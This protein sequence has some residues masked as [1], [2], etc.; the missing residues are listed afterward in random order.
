MRCTIVERAVGAGES[1]NSSFGHEA[2]TRS[3]HRSHTRNTLYSWP[4]VARGARRLHLKFAL[5]KAPITSGAHF[6]ARERSA[7]RHAPSHC[8]ARRAPLPKLRSCWRRRCA[9]QCLCVARPPSAQ[10][11]VARRRP[12]A[13]AAASPL[14]R[15]LPLHLVLAH[16]L[17]RLC[18]CHCRRNRRRRCC[19]CSMRL[20]RRAV[21]AAASSAP[22]APFCD[23]CAKNLAPLS[24][25]ICCAHALCNNLA[26][27]VDCFSV[28]A[29]DRAPHRPNHPYRVI[30]NTLQP[31]FHPD[32][33]AS[34]EY[35][36]LTAMSQY[37]PNH[38]KPVSEYVGKGMIKCQNHYESVYLQPT[39][40]SI[41]FPVSLLHEPQSSNVAAATDNLAPQQLAPPPQST[42]TPSQNAPRTES[43][44]APKRDDFDVEWDDAAENLIADLN[45][46]SID[47][48]HAD[49]ATLNVLEHFNARLQR[50]YA[51]K[52]YLLEGGI[53][54]FSEDASHCLRNEQTLSNRLYALSWLMDHARFKAF[55]ESVMNEFRRAKSTYA[56]GC[57]QKEKRKARDLDANGKAARSKTNVQKRRRTGKAR[58]TPF[59]KRK[60]SSAKKHDECPPSP[61]ADATMPN[62]PASAPMSPNSPASPSLSAQLQVQPSPAFLRKAKKLRQMVSS[63]RTP[64]PPKPVDDMEDASQLSPAERNLCSTLHIPPTFLLEMKSVTLLTVTALQQRRRNEKQSSSEKIIVPP[65]NFAQKLDHMDEHSASTTKEDAN[66]VKEKEALI[67]PPLTLPQIVNSHVLLNSGEHA[68]E[69]HR[70]SQS[71]S[72]TSR[73]MDKELLDFLTHIPE[74]N[75]SPDIKQ[76]PDLIGK[77]QGRNGNGMRLAGG[78]SVKEEAKV[79]L[80]KEENV[81]LSE[82]CGEAMGKGQCS[83]SAKDERYSLFHST[84]KRLARGLGETQLKTSTLSVSLPKSKNTPSRTSEGGSNHFMPPSTA[85]AQT[86][87]VSHKEHSSAIAELSAPISEGS[88]RVFEISKQPGVQTQP[89]VPSRPPSVLRLVL[90]P[91]HAL[92][93]GV[94]SANPNPDEV[95]EGYDLRPENQVR[96]MDGAATRQGH[97]APLISQ[98][99][100][101]E[102]RDLSHHVPRERR[103]YL[104]STAHQS[105]QGGLSRVP[106][107]VIPTGNMNVS[108]ATGHLQLPQSLARFS[109][110]YSRSAERDSTGNNATGAKCGYMQQARTPASDQNV[111]ESKGQSSPEYKKCK[112][113]AVAANLMMRPKASASDD[114]GKAELQASIFEHARDVPNINAVAG[115]VY[116]P[117]P[118]PPSS[119]SPGVVVE[120]KSVSVGGHDTHIAPTLTKSVV[121]DSETLAAIPAEG[122]EGMSGHRL[123][124]ST[125]GGTSPV[126]ARGA[127]EKESGEHEGFNSHEVISAEREDKPNSSV[128]E[129]SKLHSTQNSRNE[130]KRDC[131]GVTDEDVGS[132]IEEILLDEGKAETDFD[133]GQD[134]AH[135]SISSSA[136]EPESKPGSDDPDYQ[137]SIESRREAGRM[138]R[139][140]VRNSRRS[141]GAREAHRTRSGGDACRKILE[142]MDESEEVVSEG[143]AESED[144]VDQERSMAKR[145]RSLRP[146]RASP[147]KPAV[148]P[149]RRSSRIQKRSRRLTEHS[150]DPRPS[151]KRQF[152][153]LPSS[154]AEEVVISDDIAIVKEG[155]AVGNDR[156]GSSAAPGKRVRRRGK[157]SDDGKRSIPRRSS[158]RIVKKTHKAKELEIIT[159]QVD[160]HSQTLSS[161]SNKS[162]HLIPP[163]VEP[164]RTTWKYGL[165]RKWS[166]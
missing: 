116:L 100:N 71:K 2:R 78:V 56:A 164:E 108:R 23:H 92:P 86:S 58:T 50:R 161:D 125:A 54:C 137:P 69:H 114:V 19:A 138:R 38:W 128:G 83:A 96:N 88:E 25:Y 7:A 158:G 33:H 65:N 41:P 44:C 80:G 84:K 107:D 119:E 76:E 67:L 52:D 127:D 153:P 22:K 159:P 144:F 147:P 53:L 149:T 95:G 59:S 130:T 35:R 36:L 3:E 55:Y 68:D 21:H 166:S 72:E 154:Q 15:C 45:L 61:L 110:L 132:E 62:T 115:R 37:G 74:D 24:V 150:P 20:P 118:L 34:E 82:H 146:R 51:V 103:L 14:F 66:H 48:Q 143:G 18:H 124:E 160:P 162:L 31:L 16:L 81:G 40:S 6:L 79:E 30:E 11:H 42:S 10:L 8:G 94:A 12:R 28:G 109:D 85:N 104:R 126:V 49:E 131:T 117:Q 120:P 47:P 60:R 134:S 90:R 91:G 57:R 140:G 75:V 133:E 155:I 77:G 99:E 157:K 139:G 123:I 64:P 29:T 89:S 5:A 26:M 9:P 156:A 102:G 39:P 101:N 27:C 98:D 1:I 142:V 63:V 163:G 105:L 46:Q 70:P 165:R 17:A 112:R 87:A 122:F 136:E 148:A 145:K 93:N 135:E 4:P 129:A 106:M 152:S 13:P 73:V 151:K 111:H 113:D 32:W 121:K 97:D 43:P 141:K